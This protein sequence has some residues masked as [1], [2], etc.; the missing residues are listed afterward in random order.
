MKRRH[1]D[2]TRGST[3]RWMKAGGN[4]ST[5]V[6]HRD[7]VVR[8]NLDL[9]FAAETREGF[10]DGIV[11]DLVDQVMKSCG[12]GRPDIHRGAF[13]NRFQSFEDFD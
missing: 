11:D 9:D 5:V 12:A 10:V 4:P 7:A 6:L 2:F 3:F 8:V 1:H 13:A